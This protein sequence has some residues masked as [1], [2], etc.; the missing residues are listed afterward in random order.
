MQT[1]RIFLN[2]EWTA[3]ADTQ[4]SVM[5]R[6]YLFGDGIYEVIPVFNERMLGGDAHLDR[7]ENSLAGL[8][9]K[10]PFNRDAWLRL[11][12]Q[13]MEQLPGQDQYFYIQVTRG[14]PEKRDHAFSPELEPSVMAYTSPLAK[15][16]LT[17]LEAGYSAMSHEDIRWKMCHI[18]AITLLPNILARQAASQAGVDDALLFRDGQL[19]EATA[20][21]AFI[22][23]DGTLI[24]PPLSNLILPGVTRKLMLEICKNASIKVEERTISQAEVAQAD[25]II[26][27]SSTREIVP[28]VHLDGM[29]VGTGTPGQLWRQIWQAYQALKHSAKDTR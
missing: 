23:K 25:E 14:I 22:V 27:S 2:G 16:N 8:G 11:C 17:K 19:T 28:V 10:N 20:A 13:L 12:E 21:N 18:K 3:F 26:L 1:R 9:I 29:P 7:L 4:V 24:T 15:P 6:G 5:D